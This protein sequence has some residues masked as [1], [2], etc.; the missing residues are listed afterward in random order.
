M[1][2]YRT[3]VPLTFSESFFDLFS[4]GYVVSNDMNNSFAVNLDCAPENFHITN[5]AVSSAVLTDKY[6]L[7]L[8]NNFFQAADD[9]FR[10][11][12]IN[13]LGI[14]LPELFNRP[15]IPVR[16]SLIDIEHLSCFW[17]EKGLNCR[18]TVKK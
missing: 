8:F 15:P 1:L 7:L 4:L 9:S 10:R 11:K 12:S 13:I 17:I 14:H 18:M 6:I 16:S 3:K 5:G 2:G